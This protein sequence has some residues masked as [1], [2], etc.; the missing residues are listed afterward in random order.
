MQLSASTSALVSVIIPNYNHAPYLPKRIES[1][2]NQTYEHLEIIILDDCSPDTSREII[3][4]FAQR[5][6]R[7]QTCFNDQN[8]GSTFKQWNKGIG[9]ASGKYIWIAESDDYADARFLE[10]LVTRLEADAAIGLAYCDSWHVYE[11]K[12]TIE[13]NPGYYTSLD[14]TLW[15]HDFVLDGRELITR[16]MSYAN[17]IPNASAV[18]LRRSVVDAVPL[19]DGQSWKLVGDWLYWASIMA[20]SKV[21]YVAQPLN[22]FRFHGN[23]VRSSK[24]A[25]GLALAEFV[26]VLHPLRQYGPPEPNLYN[27]KVSEHIK[28][29]I[30]CMVHPDYDIPM[31][32]HRQI[33][34][35]FAAVHPNFAWRLIT[36]ITHFL[37][38]NKFSG[39]RQLIGDKLLP[40]LR[41]R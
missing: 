14:A 41:K 17:I 16:F 35:A 21:A 22:Y 36:E 29:W 12:Q 34:Q 4:D 7:I 3:R 26:Q 9:L 2:L 8:S 19:P 5:D 40:A 33:Y 24:V 6:K 37:I 27:H 39:I 15:Q 25:N 11:D 32:R 20:V 31:H 28:F 18:V 1:V 30:H 38:A 23:N 13:R 10:E